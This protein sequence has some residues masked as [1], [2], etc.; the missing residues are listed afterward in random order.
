MGFLCSYEKSVKQIVSNKLEI[1]IYLHQQSWSNYLSYFSIS[2]YYYR[3]VHN[4]IQ[5]KKVKLTKMNWCYFLL[6][7]KFWYLLSSDFD[8]ISNGL[9]KASPCDQRSTFYIYNWIQC[10]SCIKFFWNL[11]SMFH[12]KR[13]RL[14]ID[15]FFASAIRNAIDW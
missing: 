4:I 12:F 2:N 13:C 3:L 9:P 14:L 10:M 11:W 6:L 7:Y 5:Y 8:A 15:S 1:I